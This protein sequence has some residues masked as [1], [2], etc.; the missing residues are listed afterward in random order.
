M[1][2]FHTYAIYAVKS[3][4]VSY[5]LRIRKEDASSPSKRSPV[6]ARCSYKRCRQ[7]QGGWMSTGPVHRLSG[8]DGPHCNC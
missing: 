1:N 6:C 2:T 5:G 8:D 3:P 4:I 7:N